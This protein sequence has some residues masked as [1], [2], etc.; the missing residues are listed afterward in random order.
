MLD[1][2]WHDNELAGP[3]VAANVP[4]LHPQSPVYDEEQLVFRLVMVPDELPR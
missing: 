2:A 3:N 4:E 1:P